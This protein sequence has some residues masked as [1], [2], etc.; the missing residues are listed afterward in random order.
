MQSSIFVQEFTGMTDHLKAFAFKLT[1]DHTLADDL[2][3]DTALKAFKSRMKFKEGTNM[4]AWLLTIMRNS[5][6]NDYRK[7]QRKPKL[8]D[9]TDEQILLNNS[10]Q[11]IGNLGEEKLL[12]SPIIQ[13]IKK[14]SDDIRIPFLMA[15]KG[16][17][18]NEIAEELQLP[19]GTV[20]SRIFMARKE[21]KQQLKEIY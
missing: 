3:Q 16:Y 2:V 11:S 19:L 1:R 9:H 5:F 18:Y 8:Q 13:L 12:V 4:K 7:R 15:Y 14:L 21:L 6:I 20:K 17:S 10:N